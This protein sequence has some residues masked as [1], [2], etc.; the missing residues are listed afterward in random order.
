MFFTYYKYLILIDTASPIVITSTISEEQ[1]KNPVNVS[2]S[3]TVA[4]MLFD[5]KRYGF[6]KQR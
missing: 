5:I 1:R 3:A 2:V 6:L 4:Q